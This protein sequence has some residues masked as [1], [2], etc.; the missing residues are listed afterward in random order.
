MTKCVM[1]PG[2]GLGVCGIVPYE[3]EKGI[4]YKVC[5]GEGGHSSFPGVNE[6]SRKFYDFMRLQ[7]SNFYQIFLELL[8]QDLNHI[9]KWH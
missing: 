3:T 7:I 2:T 9:I 4:K 1:G 5:P 6:E 8:I